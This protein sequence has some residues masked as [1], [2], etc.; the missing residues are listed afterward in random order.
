LCRQHGGADHP[1][2][3]HQHPTSSQSRH[4][5]RS[6]IVRQSRYR[7]ITMHHVP[8]W[9]LSSLLP[10][11]IVPSSGIRQPKTANSLAGTPSRRR[12]H[13]IRCRGKPLFVR[14]IT[15]CVAYYRFILYANCDA[16]HILRK[17]RLLF[18]VS[19]SKVTQIPLRVKSSGES[20]GIP[21]LR[22]GYCSLKIAETEA[23][24]R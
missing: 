10:E 2:A 23:R 14:S 7:P 16:R 3:Q 19:Y 4:L 18:P 11:I 6:R 21:W 24:T 9:V 5:S 13:W 17:G 15:P 8:P 20:D 12:I 1:G 22:H